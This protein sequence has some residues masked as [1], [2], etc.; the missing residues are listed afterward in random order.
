MAATSAPYRIVVGTDFSE[1][2]NRALDEALAL[3]RSHEPAELHVVAVVE[4]DHDQLIPLAD[5]G[6][7]L[8][9]ITDRVRV[10][11]AAEAS[12]ALARFTDRVPSSVRLRATAHVRV[13]Q[14][15]VQLASLA[16]EIGADVVVV[17]THGR[18]GIERF[19]MGSV[20]EKTVRLAPCPVLVVRPKDTRGMQGLPEILPPCP[21]C[22]A[23][24]ARSEG[25]TWWCE[26]HVS[27]PEEAHTYSHSHRLEDP[28]SPTPFG[29]RQ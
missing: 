7:S 18:R 8:V 25:A 14:I 16:V 9:E 21:A 12:A 17:G 11:L 22:V 13:G 19:M 6:Q 29:S 1:L 3:T 20:A 28:Y 23:A 4:S 26:V 5:R 10:R 15:A 27:T 24:R 2:A